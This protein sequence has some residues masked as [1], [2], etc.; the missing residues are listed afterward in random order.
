MFCAVTFYDGPPADMASL[1]YD[2]EVKKG[3]RL[4]LTWTFDP[5]APKGICLRCRYS[6]TAAVL[7]RELPKGTTGARVVLDTTEHMDGYDRIVSIELR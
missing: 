2:S 4:V 1:V 7:D 3:P 6:G 5:H